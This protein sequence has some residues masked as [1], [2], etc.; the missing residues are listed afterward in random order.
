VSAGAYNTT[1]NGLGD[2]VVCKL[3]SNGNALLGSTYVGGT[4]DDG[5]NTAAGLSS[6]GD[7]KYNYGDDAR[8]EIV[9]DAAGNCVVVSCTRSLDFPVPAGAY[10]PAL[11]GGGQDG[12]IF[13]LNAS[14]THMIWASYLGGSGMDAIYS[15]VFDPSGNIYVTGGTSSTDF[16]TTAGTLHPSLMG[17]TDG[18]IAHLSSN[19]TGAA[20]I[21]L[22]RHFILRPDFFCTARRPRQCLYHGTNNRCLSGECGRLF[23]SR[24]LTVHP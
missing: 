14:L 17:G 9:L 10:Q 22:Y 3:S 21:N 12:V 13:K 4:R 23:E 18:Y 16:P 6:S 1:K 24:Q 5:V 11:A 15:C 19:G 20:S 7:I 8:G 2:I